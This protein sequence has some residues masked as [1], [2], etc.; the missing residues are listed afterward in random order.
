MQRPVLVIFTIFFLALF[1]RAQDVWMIPNAGQWDDRIEYKVD[2]QMGEMLIEKDGFTYFLHNAKQKRSH[3]HDEDGEHDHAEIETAYEAQ[4]IRSKF[5]ESTWRG[6]VVLKDSSTFYTNYILGNDPSQW[7]GHLHSY[8]HLSMLD[9]YAGVNLILDGRNGGMK[10]SLEVAPG[11][12]PNQI[13]MNYEGQDKVFLDE[14]GNLHVT[15]RF[16]EIIEEKPV[17]WVVTENSRKEVAIEFSVQ[18]NTVHFI[19]PNGYDESQTLVIDPNITFSTFSGSLADNWGMS[20]TPDSDGNLIGGGSVFGLGYPITSGAYDASFNGGNIDAGITKFNT[21][22]TALIF[23]T[24]IGGNG[25]ETPNSM[26]CSAT[27]EVYIFGLT[28]SSNFPMAGSP[29]DNSF[30]GGPNISSVT[31]TMGFAEGVDMF[32]ARLSADGSSLLASTYM[33]GSGTDGYNWGS[34]QYNYGDQFRGEIVLDDANN[35]YVASTTASPNFPVVGGPQGS[36]S[37]AQDAI[38]FKMPPTLS[39]LTWSGYYG[40]NGLET[41]NS[42]QVAANGDVY[43]AG[44]TSSTNTPFSTGFDVS[45]GGDRDGYVVRLNGNTGAILSGTLM[46]AAE[47]EQAYFVQLDV[48]DYVYVLGQSESNMGITPTHYGNANSG[49]YIRKYNH[50]LTTM[51][52]GTTIGAGSGHVEIS[53]TAFLVSDC[54]DIYFSGW[55]GDLNVN[56]GQAAFSS[57]NGFPITSGP[58]NTAFQSTTNGSNFYICVLGQDALTLKYGTYMGGVTGSSNHVDGGTSRFDKS[59]R[60][61]HAVCA[62]CSGNPNGFTSTPG[63]WSTTNQSSNCNLAAF[64]FELSTIEALVTT[65]NTVVCLPDPVIFS[66]NSANGNSFFWDFGDGSTSTLMNPTHVYPGPGTYLV[67]LVVSDSF[68]CFTPDSVQFE[69]FIGDFQ[70]GAIQPTEPVCPGEPYGLE[71]YGGT[72]YE[73]SPPQYLDDPTSATPTATIDV[74][75]DFM[76]I[77]SDTCGTDTAY[78]TLEVYAGAGDISNDTSIC[79]GN[80][81]YLNAS[82]GVSYTWSPPTYLDDPTSPTPLCTPDATTEYTVEIITPEGCTVEE[83]VLVSVYYTPPIPVMPDLLNLCYGSSAEVT[84]SGGETYLWSPNTNITPID[85][86]VVTINP[87][88]DMWYYCDFTNACGTVRDSMEVV[89]VVASITA[90]TDTIICPGESVDL[91]AAGGV[92]YTWSPAATLNHNN[93]SLVT[94]TPTEPTMYYVTGMDEYGCVN[95]DSVWVD[96]YPM[97][98]IQA[99]PDVYAFYGDLIELSATSTTTGPYIWSP[100]EF[101]TCV[102]CPNPI[103]NPNQNFG[104]M[105]SYIDENGCEASDSVYIYYDPIIYVPNTF[106]PNDDSMNPMF[107]AEG[108][109]IKT[110]EML[111]FDRW[112]E[113][114]FTS[115]DMSVGWD[116]TFEGNICQDGTYVW[117]IKISDFNDE[118]HDYIGHI[119][120]L[121]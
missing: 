46:G 22:G 76:V 90:G 95:D 52:W 24:Y 75:T 4:V 68:G 50:N 106:T 55:G 74:T 1:T 34:L 9:F 49:Q 116:G 119:N 82:G 70:G 26:I 8:S 56:L 61:Y 77:I 43:M 59:G 12:D 33:G 104:Y 80:N 111:I 93:T 96:L 112:G 67:N 118:E 53:P 37:G 91:W 83:T 42:V 5:L 103:A 69:V 98:F 48:D 84:V 15:N 86:S 72:M 85:S 71:A 16:G 81:F 105:V 41:G 117:K 89:I 14:D 87:L 31:Y 121:R 60:I 115:N 100:A 63:V 120:L 17:A 32:V 51:E 101:L 35:V 45:Y 39:S 18:G 108:G 20:A 73:W 114:I 65:P 47:Y 23:S 109:N 58:T 3:V 36:L 57:S 102:V 62:A 29:Y 107:L 44:G 11:V 113:L 13:Q 64:K 79:I 38:V 92:S 40:G 21:D 2:L 97:A 27:D 88:T 7:K 19:F 99:S 94:A 6:D 54:Y 66:N 30:A 78:V 28:S 10:Y 25:S 110:F